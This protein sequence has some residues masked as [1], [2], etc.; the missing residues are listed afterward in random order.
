MVLRPSLCSS[1]ACRNPSLCLSEKHLPPILAGQPPPSLP[2]VTPDRAAL[3]GLSHPAP[4]SSGRESPARAASAASGLTQRGAGTAAR[5]EPHRCCARVLS[6][7]P[8][9]AARAPAGRPSG[10]PE[11]AAR[12]GFGEGDSEDCSRAPGNPSLP[13]GVAMGDLFWGGLVYCGC[14]LSPAAVQNFVPRS[15]QVPAAVSGTIAPPEPSPPRSCPS[16]LEP[17]GSAEVLL[18]EFSR[19][20]LG[21]VFR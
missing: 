13:L 18:G 19:G 2:A 9:R 5:A 17:K 14:T 8:L 12:K 16:S 3:P 15:L 1:S 21:L 20:V 6:R 10:K 4:R 11:L 7:T